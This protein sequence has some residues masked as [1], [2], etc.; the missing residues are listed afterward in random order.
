MS[1]A[2]GD[3]LI[4]TST[5]NGTVDFSTTL[6]GT[7]NLD[8]LSGSGQVTITGN[9]G[10]SNALTSLDINQTAG[11]GN[12]RILGNIG[13]DSASGAGVVRLGNDNNTG[14]ITFGTSGT[15][16]DYFTTG[17]QTYIADGYSLAGTDPDF[18]ASSENI[19]FQDGDNGMTLAAG[20]DLTVDTG[21]GEDGNINIEAAIA[22]T[23]GETT[24]VTL[25][26]GSGTVTVYGMATGIG[27][28]T[29]DG[30]GGVTLNGNNTTN[31]SN[32][33]ITDATT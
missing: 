18:N 21:S 33:D 24:D 26:A 4:D 10:T 9:I 17:A 20:S 16:G 2:T 23:S 1:L 31:A 13:T 15:A 27:D 5:S 3:I 8:I 22:S 28:V 11:T 19:D 25:E 29:I 14:T 6:D 30:S 32:I 7:Q 12:I